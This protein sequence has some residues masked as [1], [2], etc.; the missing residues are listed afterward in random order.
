MS[1]LVEVKLYKTMANPAAVF[2]SETWAVGEM[3]VKRLGAW[4]RK[5]YVPVVEQGMWRIKTDQELRE[6]YK[7]LDI[8]EEIK[9]EEIGMGWACSKNGLGKES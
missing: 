9:K 6:L 7:Y 2:G 5:I 3:D 1:H 8:G 4:E